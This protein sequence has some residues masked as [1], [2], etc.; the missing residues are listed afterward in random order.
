[1]I[2]ENDA[3]PPHLTGIVVCLP[4]CHWCFGLGDA[5]D[6][7]SK[8]EMCDCQ[9][10][11][12]GKA[13]R[14]GRHGRRGS[15]WIV[16]Q[17]TNVIGTMPGSSL[18]NLNTRQLHSSLQET[19]PHSSVYICRGTAS[20]LLCTF[21]NHTKLIYKSCNALTYSPTLHPALA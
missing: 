4:D 1:M 19:A 13:I 21:P 9:S 17:F 18:I 8:P 15:F 6:T 16:S 14:H 2:N 7:E 3:G 12:I 5:L 11:A 10:G 20:G